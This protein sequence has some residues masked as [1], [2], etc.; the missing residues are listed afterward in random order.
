MRATKAGSGG[1]TASASRT[2]RPSA[3][4]AAAIRRQALTLMPRSPASRCDLLIR[5]STA[6]LRRSPR[7]KEAFEG[8]AG[9][10]IL[11]GGVARSGPVVAKS[12][13]HLV[14]FALQLARPSDR[15]NVPN[16]QLV[17][18]QETSK[19]PVFDAIRTVQLRGAQMHRDQNGEFLAHALS[20]RLF[21]RRNCDWRLP[22]PR[23]ALERQ[24]STTPA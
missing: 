8:R 17:V 11:P 5:S 6:C 18:P 4:A 2:A 23:P 1:G 3:A 10:E 20:S 19:P 13:V 15:E 24:T 16:R 9:A 21:V 12:G 22:R 14:D 7:L